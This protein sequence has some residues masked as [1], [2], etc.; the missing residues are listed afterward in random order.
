MK[1]KTMVNSMARGLAA[2]LLS[3][4]VAAAQAP[5][6]A[7]TPPGAGGAPSLSV[8]VADEAAI[9]E[10]QAAIERFKQGDGAGALAQFEAAAKARPDLPPARLMLARL[11]INTGQVA[12][13]RAM[14]EDAAAATRHRPDIHNVFGNLG[15]LEGRLTDAQLQFERARALLRTPPA[16]TRPLPRAAADEAARHAVSGLAAVAERRRSW[17]EALT[18]LDELK[19]LQPADAATRQRIG[20]ALFSTGRM[21]EA[22]AAL[23]EANR[24]N[25]A[26]DPPE[27]TIG[28]MQLEA[29][30][31]AEAEA[32][33][34]AAVKANPRGAP[35]QAAMA[36][37]LLRRERLA[38]AKP[39]AEAAL[40][41]EPNSNL[42]RRL[43]AQVARLEG[44]LPKSEELLAPVVAADPGDLASAD[45][46]VLALA[47]QEDAAKRDRA[48]TLA[49]DTLRKA[50]SRTDGLIALGYAYQ[51]VG[52]LDEALQAMRAATPSGQATAD[53][54]Y[55]L[56]SL[57]AARGETAEALRLLRAALT[58]P[59]GQFTMRAAAKQKL[60]GL[61][62]LEAVRPGGR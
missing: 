14:L 40:A 28:W 36:A 32:S 6:P 45:G 13:G 21:D 33:L 62:A 2:V 31:P 49:Q 52:R 55:Y 30:Q 4:G 48:V 54:A 7:T 56:G 17:A 26:L 20:R 60:Q 27:I 53:V 1:I 57:Q 34:A 15:L 43:L 22:R 59:V 37:F 5:P 51:R 18:L 8:G 42:A 38:E 58:A 29:N 25:P 9:P 50:P 11:L 39:H 19:A 12:P 23:Q 10:I 44:D 46:L 41:I 24:L 47:G 16:G 35:A 3:A 61:E